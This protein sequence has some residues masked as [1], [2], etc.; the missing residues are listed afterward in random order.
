MNWIFQNKATVN[1]NPIDKLI[2]ELKEENERLKKSLGGGPVELGSEAAGM[3]EEEKAAMRAEIE[4][5]LRAQ[6]SFRFLPSNL[7]II[8]CCGAF[9]P[10]GSWKHVKLQANADLITD[11]NA[12][13]SK[14]LASSQ[15]E[16]AQ[17]AAQGTVPSILTLAISINIQ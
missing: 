4:A 17:L 11:N 14:Q 3:T 13:F 7:L 12:D 2:R 6:E 10:H 9:N 15:A 5:E 8:W 1:E 16:D